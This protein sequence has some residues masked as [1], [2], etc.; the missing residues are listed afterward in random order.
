MCDRLCAVSILAV[1]AIVLVGCAVDAA[2]AADRLDDATRR[3]VVKALDPLLERFDANND[4]ALSGIE[5]KAL[6]DHVMDKAGSL[7]F[8]L[9]QAEALI[10]TI[11]EERDLTN[12][13]RAAVTEAR[14]DIP[15]A[16]AG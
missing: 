15:E 3:R 11:R 8:Q 13:L 14:D 10:Q 2:T 6:L 1:S 7:T 5:Q 4:K 9:K 16:R 12:K